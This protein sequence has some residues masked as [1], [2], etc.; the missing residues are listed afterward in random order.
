[1]V[2]PNLI[3][4]IIV[5]TFIVYGQSLGNGFVTWDDGL[6][7]TENP[8][9]RG[10]SF[11]NLWLAFTSYDPEL[12]IPLTF[13]S[14]QINYMIGG[15]QPFGYH[16]GNL[17]LHISNAVLVAMIIGRLPNG[18]LKIENGKL[19]SIFNFQFSII[20][21]LLFAVH[22][23]HT[24]AVVWAAARKDVLSAFFFL[25]TVLCYLR[26]RFDTRRSVMVSSPELGEGRIEPG[27]AALLSVT[28]IWNGM[29]WLSVL[30]FLLALLSK[31][32]VITW[33]VLMVLMDWYIAP[34]PK[35]G[36]PAAD[37]VKRAL[38]FAIL[39]LIF[40]IIAL[41]GKIANTGF[42]YEKFLMGCR[43]ITL[44]LQ[45]FFWPS[46]LSALYPFTKPVS[47]FTPELFLSVLFALFVSVVVLS[48]AARRGVRLPLFAWGWFLLLLAPSFSNITKGH[49]ELLDIYITTDR[50]AYLPSIGLLI[51]V[52]FLI[53]YV[54][55]KLPVLTSSTVFFVLF[56]FSVLSYK[57][58]L[59]WKNT[60][61]LFTHVSEAQPRA[62]VAWSNIGTE[63]V[64]RGRLHEGLQAYSKALQIRDD[65]TTW[66][67]VGQILRAQ[68]K[69]ELAMQAYERAVASSPLEE[70]AKRAL[71]EL[72][73][74]N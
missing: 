5:L 71:E 27:P 38:P 50:Y 39:S 10:L 13:L 26:S 74:E 35:V 32:S 16:L 48:C 7:I 42:L 11:H 12:Y 69:R 55:R 49:N 52:V 60:L 56:V 18:K 31:V 40:G 3:L 68:G 19:F 8:I 21:G 43:A 14:Y 58:S 34:V 61:T 72:R 29:Y 73:M 1:M 17:L 6:L 25:L 22:P 45:K 59:V 51:V 65:A 41:G 4:G 54:F 66:Y 64:R 67:N 46:G 36:T 30:M 2:R 9:I 15:L 24:E 33:P 23:L 28:Q 62:Y 70:D 53:F 44:L 20:A 57:Q 63:E 47:L 37:S